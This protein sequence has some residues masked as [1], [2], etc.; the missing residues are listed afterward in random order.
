MFLCFYAL[1]FIMCSLSLFNPASQL[2][3]INK[4]RWVELSRVGPSWSQLW[5][6]RHSP[7]W[8]A[9]QHMTLSS[10]KAFRL[11]KWC[12]W[13]T[14][15]CS[16]CVSF[17]STASFCR[18]AKSFTD[19]IVE[20]HWNTFVRR[21]DRLLSYRLI[22]SHFYKI[23]DS[24]YAFASK[25]AYNAVDSRNAFAEERCLHCLH[26]QSEPIKCCCWCT[27]LQRHPS[28]SQPLTHTP[29][30]MSECTCLRLAKTST[31]YCKK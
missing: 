8:T 21:C 18:W 27:F 3:Y 11:M 29:I 26:C 12:N 22:S 19:E 14:G 24:L 25:Q 5:R 20:I 1:C 17:I 4:L 15:M 23:I 6:C 10:I 13:R 7:G 31:V 9:K 2:P 16:G 28:I 30:S